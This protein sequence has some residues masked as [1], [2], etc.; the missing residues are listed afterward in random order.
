MLVQ[1]GTFD[2]DFAGFE[3]RSFCDFGP[4]IPREGKRIDRIGHYRATDAEVVF[5]N[6]VTDSISSIVT[7]LVTAPEFRRARSIESMSKCIAPIGRANSRSIIVFPAAGSPAKMTSL[8]AA[9]RAYRPAVWGCQRC[10]DST[11]PERSR[12]LYAQGPWNS[13]PRA[14][15]K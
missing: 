7:G 6:G 8:A 12:R 4:G 9:F 3:P 15:S 5:A 1:V 14:R 2:F 10:V 11:S 13:C